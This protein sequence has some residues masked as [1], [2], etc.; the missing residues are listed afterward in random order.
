MVGLRDHREP[1]VRQPLDQVDLPQGP[2]PVQPPPEQPAHQRTQLLVGAGGGQ[3]GVADVIVEVEVGVVDPHRQTQMRG[4]SRT[5][6]RQRGTSPS[7]CPISATNASKSNPS[8]AAKVITPPM[9]IGRVRSSAKRKDASSG[10]R[11]S[12]TPSRVGLPSG[13]HPSRVAVPVAHD[14]PV[15]D[16]VGD[17]PLIGAA[18]LE[19]PYWARS[20][21]EASQAGIWTVARGAPRTAVLLTAWSWRAAPR[22]TLVAVTLQLAAAVATAFGLLS[23]VDVFT[24]LLAAGPTPERVAD[25]LPA[26]A[27][28]VGALVARAALQ[29]ASGSVQARLVPRIEERAQDELYTGLADVELAAFDDSDYTEVVHRRTGAAAPALRLVARR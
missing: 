18:E 9:C 1:A 4:Y 7:R 15:G 8:G 28:V 27:V 13:A 25:A 24:N 26:L 23:T 14:G 21:L 5:F 6:C 17:E 22:W 20:Q 3:G 29:A 12:G 10:D 19:T 16:A 11:R 2:R